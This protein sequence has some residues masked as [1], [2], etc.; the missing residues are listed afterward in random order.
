MPNDRTGY[1]GRKHNLEL[2][3]NRPQLRRYQLDDLAAINNAFEEDRCV[4]YQGP[5]GSGKTVLATEFIRRR[6]DRRILV[7]THRDEIMRQ[8]SRAFE[9]LDLEHGIIAPGYPET[10]RRVQLALVMTLSRRLGRMDQT[11]TLIIID[12]AHHAAAKTLRKIIRAFPHADI[13]GLT[14]TPRRLDGKPLDDIFDKMVTGPSVA[15]LIDE[16]WLAPVTVFVPP[17][18]PD[19]ARVK[20]RAGDYN[21]GQL[22]PEMYK[23]IIVDGAIAEYERRCPKA[24]AIVFCVDIHHSK[25]VAEA[26]RGRGYRCKHVDGGTPRKQRRALIRALGNGRIDVL[27]NCGLIAE[28]L[29]VPGVECVI[30]LRP[31]QSLALYLQ[32]VGRALRPGKERAIIL[33]HAGNV[34]RHG[35]PTAGRRWSLHGSLLDDCG[36][37]LRRCRVCGAVNPQG[38]VECTNCGEQLSQGPRK[39]PMIIPGQRLAEAIATPVTDGDIAGMTYQECLKW[40]RADGGKF[41]GDRLKRIARVR[42]FKPGW[43]YYARREGKRA[44]SDR[45]A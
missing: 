21:L 40:A 22:G 3:Q 36:D 5:T 29:D 26:F 19:L 4:L 43:V 2:Q 45:A 30:C 12:E 10:K 34:Y 18:I 7:V 37:G 28:G 42:G 17:R 25:L 41:S 14:A 15:K 1:L 24:P 38:A 13:L 32:M 35:L 9:R 20:I 39:A 16:G 11:P 23:G 44:G 8:F 33:D 6:C 27:T 31:T